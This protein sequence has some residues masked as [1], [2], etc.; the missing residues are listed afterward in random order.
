MYVRKTYI[1]NVELICY[2]YITGMR[3]RISI[4]LSNNKINKLDSE[5]VQWKYKFLFYYAILYKMNTLSRLCKIPN[6]RI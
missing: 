6:E 3:L 5:K 1:R 2:N 4:T